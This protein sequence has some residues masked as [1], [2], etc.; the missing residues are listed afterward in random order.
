MRVEGRNASSWTDNRRQRAQPQVSQSKRNRRYCTL[1]PSDSE[2][3]NG[4]YPG[5]PHPGPLPVGE[6]ERT[7]LTQWARP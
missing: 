3:K 6:G 7:A 4:P 1:S 2:A 5:G